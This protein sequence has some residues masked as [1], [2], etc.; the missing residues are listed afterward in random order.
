MNLFKLG[1]FKSHSGLELDWKVECDALLIEDWD[2]AAKMVASQ[3][4]FGSVIG[5][6]S[7]G[8]KFAKALEKYTTFGQT[9]IVD[10]VLTAGAS[11][12]KLMKENKSSL[13]W[14][15]FSRDHDLIGYRHGYGEIRAIW[16]L[17]AKSLG[18]KNIDIYR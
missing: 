9:I 4:K 3:T 5:V 6:P 7:G 15:L 18:M 13:G 11:I 8:L 2:W 10:D 17:N 14:V 12:L 16:T 1:K